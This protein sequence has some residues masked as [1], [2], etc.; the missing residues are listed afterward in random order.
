MFN[1]TLQYLEKYSKIVQQM[2]CTFA[3]FKVLN[4]KVCM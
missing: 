3:Y 1:V 4:L 2:A